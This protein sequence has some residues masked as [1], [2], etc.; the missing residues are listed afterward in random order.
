MVAGGVS[1]LVDAAAVAVIAAV[2]PGDEF[3]VVLGVEING[4][5]GGA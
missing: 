4:A 1:G 5:L 2:L 3:A